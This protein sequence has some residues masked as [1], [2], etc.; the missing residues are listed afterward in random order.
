LIKNDENHWI[1]CT[2]AII[3]NRDSCI[4]KPGLT[5]AVKAIDVKKLKKLLNLVISGF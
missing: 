4:K 2:H 1:G 3:N 5:G